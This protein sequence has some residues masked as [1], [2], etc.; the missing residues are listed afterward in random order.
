MPA[1]V[2]V[3]RW[4]GRPG[5]TARLSPCFAS[6]EGQVV[7]THWT[8]PLTLEA[9]LPGPRPGAGTRC[10]QRRAHTHLGSGRASLAWR[11]VRLGRVG[12]RLV[13]NARFRTGCSKGS[14]APNGDLQLRLLSQGQSRTPR[15]VELNCDPPSAVIARECCT[16][17]VC[18]PA[19]GGGTG[20]QHSGNGHPAQCSGM[21]WVPRG[22][23]HA[24][25]QGCSV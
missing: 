15:S 10:V 8:S 9:A 6:S 1:M 16:C 13:K 19:C 25:G 7:P 24:F 21:P 12:L 11:P 3:L 5:G 23:G 4:H 20:N 18:W 22:Q 14:A 2:A 17:G